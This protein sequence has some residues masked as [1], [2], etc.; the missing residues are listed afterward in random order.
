MQTQNQL[1][2]PLNRSGNGRARIH[3]LTFQLL[4]KSS[5]RNRKCKSICQ[6]LFCFCCFNFLLDYAFGFRLIQFCSQNKC[7]FNFEYS[8]TWMSAVTSL[9]FNIRAAHAWKQKRAHAEAINMSESRFCRRKKSTWLGEWISPLNEIE[10][11][12][13]HFRKAENKVRSS[14]V[15][16]D[17]TQRLVWSANKSWLWDIIFDA[18]NGKK[19]D[20]N[21]HFFW[22]LVN[23]ILSR[24]C[25]SP[26]ACVCMCSLHGGCV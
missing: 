7:T 16:Y 6:L 23:V 19:N 11:V 22:I 8:T 4:W 26:F 17:T 25:R 21:Y 2:L 14:I 15:L 1:R 10:N 12:K 3:P 9:F 5:S 20:V 13:I 24:V 18:F